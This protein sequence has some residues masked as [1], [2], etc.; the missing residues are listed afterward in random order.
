MSKEELV[1]VKGGGVLTATFLNAISRAVETI[2]D[3]GRSLGSSIRMI[4][5]GTKC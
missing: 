4:I 2:Y 5:S 3:L 1:K